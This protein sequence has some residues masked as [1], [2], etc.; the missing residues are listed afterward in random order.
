VLNAAAIDVVVLH[1]TLRQGVEGT[2]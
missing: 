1:V 2:S